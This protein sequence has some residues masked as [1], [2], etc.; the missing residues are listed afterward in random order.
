MRA[1]K[2]LAIAV[3]FAIAQP[4]HAL[5][6][7]ETLLLD[8]CINARCVGVAAVIARGDDV[9]VD[10]AALQAAQLDTTGVTPEVLGERTFVSLKQLN[11]GS[12][13]KLDRNLLRLDLKLRADRLP[14][15]RVSMGTRA[16][17]DAGLQPWSSFL[18]YAASIDDDGNGLLFLD[19]AI[20]RGNAALRSTGQWDERAGWRRGVTRFEWDQPGS[21]RRWTVGDQFAVAR[22][23]LGGGG[24]IGGFGVERAFDTDPYLVTFPQPY[25]SG[26]LE[27]PGTVEIYANGALV[28]RRDVGAGP[29]TL[30]ELGISPGR[31]DVRV[32]VRDPFGNRSELATR[33]YYV[34]SP[35]LLAPGLDEYAVRIGAPRTNTIGGDYE[36]NLTWQAWYRR[37]L[38]DWLT[39]GGRVEGDDFVRNA[40]ADAAIRT[41]FGEFALAYAGSDGDGVGRGTAHAV[42]YSLAFSEWSLGLGSTRAGANYRRLADDAGLVLGALRIDDYASLAFTPGNRMTLT[43]NAGRQ[44][45]DRLPLERT[46]GATA[47]MRVWKRGELFLTAQHRTSDLFEDTSVQLSLN[48]TLDDH[49]I[50]A[51][52]RQ[53]DNGTTTTNGYGVDVN[54]SRPAG[55]GWGYYGN[56]QRDGDFDSAFAHVEY[57]GVHARFAAEGQSFDG[58]TSGSVYATGALVGIGGRMFLTPPVESG[59]ALVRVPGMANAP[60]LRENQAIGRTDAHGDLLV[61]D[62]L[63]FQANQIAID[64][65]HMP[66]TWSVAVPKRNVGVAR[67]TGS[68]VSLE[69]TIVQAVTGRLHYA[70]GAPGDALQAPNGV[71]SVIGTDGMFYLDNLAPGRAALR[72]TT[73]TGTIECTLDVPAANSA[74]V[75][76]LGD[77]TCGAGQ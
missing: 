26:V 63:P 44:Q 18:N 45:R 56:A 39:L 24:L 1:L 12:T 8:I 72:V 60:I 10:M 75:L 2:V 6:G 76:D 74:G 42:N 49:S 9:L 65:A 16:Q 3:A 51:S 37:G 70:G 46:W 21:L 17:A 31:N 22:D 20:G 14:R 35:S 28:G 67:N 38:S 30:D 77:V 64:E 68:I 15:Q 4:A 43:F 61:R 11:H 73:A 13:F 66:A 71:E 23:P 34:G 50:T 41:P 25:Y 29:F 32:I 54:H 62:L 69:G 19:G 48:F 57:Q 53:R 7:D 33:T 47:S 40:G 52:A 58:R 27:S 36:D 5:P 59:F 55:T